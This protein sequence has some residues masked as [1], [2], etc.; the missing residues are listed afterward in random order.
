[1][2][3]GDFLTTKYQVNASATPGLTETVVCPVSVQE[4][5]EAAVINGVDNDATGSDVNLNVSAKAS[6]GAREY[7]ILPRKIR[8]EW[9][10]GAPAG[11]SG[12]GGTIVILQES[13]FNGI[14][15]GQT[16]T[17]AGGSIRVTGKL[18]ENLR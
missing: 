17:Y 13:V 8:F 10:G 14:S 7:G 9:D 3:A 1:M 4:E 6:R 12:S 15:V 2:S 16:G 18:Q 11:Y 5:T